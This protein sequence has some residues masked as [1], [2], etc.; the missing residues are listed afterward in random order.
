[1][2]I[3]ITG[4]TSG[5]GEASLH[6]FAQNSDHIIAI[7]RNEAKLAQ[8]KLQYPDLVTPLILDIRD[9]EKVTKTLSSI[10]DIDILINNAGLALGMDP[11]QK[12]ELNDWDIMVD[13]NI[14]G[15][16]YTTHTLLPKM[17]ERK[18]GLIINVGSIAG[19]Y[20]YP[21]GHVYGATKSFIHQFSLNLRADLA[22][23]NVRVTCLEPGMV[24]TNFSEI[25]YKG[26][27][28]KANKAYENI[29]YL[30]SEDIAKT[31]FWISTL[32]SHI[33]INVLEIM[34]TAQSF[35]RFHYERRS[36]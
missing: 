6:L 30:T 16:L 13:S 27:H 25:R 21:G 29:A 2:K 26:N 32:P 31:I 20:P 36:I 34:P 22:G 7:G 10:N 33:N 3:C 4:A 15:V 11:A 12:S 28:E 1:M 24:K 18:Q 19:T 5:I 14:K 23:T 35:G 9:K 17:V 8:L